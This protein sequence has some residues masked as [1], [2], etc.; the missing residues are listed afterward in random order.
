[1]VFEPQYDLSMENEPIL[2]IEIDGLLV[3]F[4]IKEEGLRFR[5]AETAIV[6]LD[7]IVNEEQARKLCGLSVFLK[8][9]D[10]VV[11]EEE[12]SI[13]HLVGFVLYD[14]QIGEIGPIER[15]EDY[16]GNLLFQL[17]YQGREILVPFNEDL[18]TELDEQERRIKM[19]CPDGI[20]DL[21]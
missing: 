5:S 6:Q 9:E 21:D 10:V 8:N 20:F 13:H 18:L 14:T 7:W 11:P 15:V 3:P 12:L 1:M 16:G 4:F 17:Q 2:M 19:Q